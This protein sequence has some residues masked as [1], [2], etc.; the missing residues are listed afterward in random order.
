VLAFAHNSHLQRGK[1]QWQLG[2]AVYTALNQPNKDG[3]FVYISPGGH[4]G[5]R[6]MLERIEA[7]DGHLTLHPS[8][9]QGTTIEVELPLAPSEPL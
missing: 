9:E 1:S 8:K 6:G 7:I 5:L 3:S 2:T 4:Y